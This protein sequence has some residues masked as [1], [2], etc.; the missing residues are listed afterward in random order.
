MRIALIY[1][2]CIILMLGL[3]VQPM[4]AQNQKNS[5][6]NDNYTPTKKGTPGYLTILC[7]FYSNKDFGALVR[8]CLTKDLANTKMFGH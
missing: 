3:T 5:R 8:S 6:R 2:W 7:A 4:L 1:R